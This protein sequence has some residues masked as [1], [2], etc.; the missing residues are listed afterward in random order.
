MDVVKQLGGPCFVATRLTGF[1]CL[2]QWKAD[3]SVTLESGRILTRYS[4][5]LQDRGGRWWLAVAEERSTWAY[6]DLRIK[7]AATN[8]FAD[9]GED[10]TCVVSWP[11]RVTHHQQAGMRIESAT[12]VAKDRRHGVMRCM[13]T[14][15]A[16]YAKADWLA[17][18]SIFSP[19]EVSVIFVSVRNSTQSSRQANANC[20]ETKSRGTV[21]R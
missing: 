15:G 21:G 12:A 2:I 13:A 5:T 6:N 7:M 19:S 16:L 17:L 14:S 8:R 20:W 4:L 1:S 9:D 3:T 11:G 10:G 18:Q